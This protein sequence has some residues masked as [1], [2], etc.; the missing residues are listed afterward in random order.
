[1]FTQ[2][3]S[4]PTSGRSA[5]RR[6]PKLATRLTLG[7]E[8]LDA[9]KMLTLMGNYYPMTSTAYHS[10]PTYSSAYSS[11]SS[12]AMSMYGNAGYTST[13]AYSQSRVAYS[14]NLQTAPSSMRLSPAPMTS[15]V[16]SSFCGTPSYA[17]PTYSTYGT[18][19]YSMPMS[20]TYS[21]SYG[22]PSLYTSSPYG[23]QSVATSMSPLAKATAAN[24]AS[25]LSL[26]AKANELQRLGA[27]VPSSVTTVL[28]SY[29]YG[30]SSLGSAS[31]TGYTRAQIASMTSA[32]TQYSMKPYTGGTSSTSYMPYDS[33]YNKMLTGSMSYFANVM[34]TTTRTMNA[35]NQLVSLPSAAFSRAASYLW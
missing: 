17:M 22:S 1:M 3:P 18:S 7:V 15:Y 34:Q 31:Q 6:S 13:N 14:P 29:G 5:K 4:S 24:T 8:T 16:T 35:V 9:R 32:E 30:G 10:M 12:A 23:A 11:P 27:A 28:N 19:S 20:S 26:Q 25:L 21:Y 33:A 2:S